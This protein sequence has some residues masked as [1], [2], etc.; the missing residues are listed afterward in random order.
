M[1]ASEAFVDRPVSR[2][3]GQCSQRSPTRQQTLT[4][5]ALDQP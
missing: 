5:H 2:A 1:I 3:A 4:S